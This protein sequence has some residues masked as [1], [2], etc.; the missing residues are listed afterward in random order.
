M[1]FRSFT[2]LAF[3]IITYR[4]IIFR[5]CVELTM[6]GGV[7]IKLYAEERVPVNRYVFLDDKHVSDADIIVTHYKHF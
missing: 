6:V 7:W 3:E 5:C 4:F 1:I 2:G